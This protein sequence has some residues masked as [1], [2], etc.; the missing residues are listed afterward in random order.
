MAGF[1]VRRLAMLCATLILTGFAHA[2]RA[3]CAG[4]LSDFDMGLCQAQ[5]FND[6]DRSLNQAYQQLFTTLPSGQQTQL[7]HDELGWIGRRDQQCAASLHGNFYIDFN[8]VTNVTLARLSVL[9]AQL[10]APD[11]QMAANREYTVQGGTMPWLWVAGG[12]NS[13]YQFGIQDGTE[14]SVVSLAALNARPGQPLIIT[15]VAGQICIGPG[16][17][18]TDA[19]GT[20]NTY[21][22][23]GVA[24]TG[25]PLPSAYMQQHPINLSALVGAFTDKQGQLVAPPFTINDGPFTATIPPGATQLQLGI[26]DDNYADNIGAITVSVKRGN[27]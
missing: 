9:K 19:S 20:R 5:A 18:E 10:V 8:C 24:S 15:Y 11:I 13:T 23:D 4:V 14:P 26:N 2:A 16:W 6:A 7:R 12:L 21:A 27:P 3:D 1:F 17:P 25:R 22:N